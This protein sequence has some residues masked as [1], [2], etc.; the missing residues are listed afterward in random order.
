MNLTSARSIRDPRRKARLLGRGFGTGLGKT[1]GR[2]IKGQW[3]RTGPGIPNHFEGGQ[4]PLWRRLPKRGFN[5]GRHRSRWALMNVGDLNG[6][7][8]GST[9]DLA[10]LREAGLVSGLAEGW[11]LLGEGTLEV[12]GLAV[13]ADRA[14][15]EARKKV[16]AAG[17]KVEAIHAAP[18]KRPKRPP[19]PPKAAA[20]EAAPAKETAA[21]KAPKPPKAG[22]PL[23]EGAPKDAPAPK[24]PSPKKPPAGEAPPKA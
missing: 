5:R 24:A 8:P 2:G 14:S 13:K 22:K 16:E 4:M 10:A 11:K 3:A 23:A 12:R 19:A 17:G 18:E 20:T 21:P 9:V 15:A 7:A 1:C 6:L